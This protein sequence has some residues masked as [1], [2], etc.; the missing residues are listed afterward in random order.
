MQ[1]TIIPRASRTSR[2]KSGKTWLVGDSDLAIARAVYRYDRLN[3]SFIAALASIKKATAQERLTRFRNETQG[4]A[5]HYVRV[6]TPSFNNENIYFA[7]SRL[8]ALIE[9]RGALPYRATLLSLNG[10][11]GLAHDLMVA[12][13]TANI[14]LGLRGT[15]HNLIG[16]EEV[17]ASPDFPPR[18]VNTRREFCIPVDTIFDGKPVKFDLVPDNIFGIEGPNG[19]T[20]FAL[21]CENEN[22]IETS[23]YKRNSTKRKMIGYRA[24]SQRIDGVPH[25]TRYWGIPNLMVMF[26]A[27]TDAHVAAMKA[28][29]TKIVG[30]SGSQQFLFRTADIMR[31]R[32]PYRSPQPD[33]GFTGKWERAGH[34]PFAFA[35]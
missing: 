16:Y 32:P 1:K 7:D 31:D 27:P 9:S 34:S 33:S 4:D 35:S 30:A 15:L 5:E 23:Q 3:T 6:E 19:V 12:T 11:S 8:A 17:M 20:F 25:Y 18:E 21:E 14:E 10:G 26:V 28:T 22:T 2:Q 13:V 24:I 29:L